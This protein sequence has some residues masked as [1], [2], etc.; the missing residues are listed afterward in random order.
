M[1]GHLYDGDVAE[2]ASPRN[3]VVL[4][5]DSLNRHMLGQLWR[6]GVRHAEPRRFCRTVRPLHLARHRIAPLH[7]GT[8]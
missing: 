3:L 2:S 8:P 1:N 4:L 7:A 6:H 5:L